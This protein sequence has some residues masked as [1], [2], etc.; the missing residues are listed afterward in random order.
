MS[1]SITSRSPPATPSLLTNG[2][3]IH[4]P[5]LTPDILST[6]KKLYD[7]YGPIPRLLLHRRM[8]IENMEIFFKK[9]DVA[10]KGKIHS[11]LDKTGTVIEENH[12]G[13]EPS[14]TVSLIVPW[15]GKNDIQVGQLYYVRLIT[16]Y[17]GTRVG[18]IAFDKHRLNAI[19]LYKT[20]LDLPTARPFAGWIFEGLVHARLRKGGEFIIERCDSSVWETFTLADSQQAAT[21]KNV[22]ALS[23]LLRKDPRSQ[24]VNSDISGLY[25]QPEI[26]NFPAADALAVLQDTV[27][28][29]IILFQMALS[30]A[31]GVKAT[32][33]DALWNVLPNSLKNSC[34]VYLVWV[35]REKES[36]SAQK[37]GGDTLEETWKKRLTQCVLKFGDAEPYWELR[38]NK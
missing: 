6:M 15:D 7:M 10:L 21:F 12:L 28:W 17:I 13:F 8:W 35:V 24:A 37:V 11:M 34:N 1:P 22:R 30:S 27:P 18:D 16:R 23:N 38:G 3:R 9:Q 2:Y 14:H 25:L 29:K 26:P 33:L 31:H 19:A 4:K 36:F 5:E 32:A 20:L